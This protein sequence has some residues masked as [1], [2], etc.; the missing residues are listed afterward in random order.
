M[1]WS[2]FEVSLLFLFFELHLH[3]SVEI[4]MFVIFYLF[5]DFRST[6]FDFIAMTADII[7]HFVI[8]KHFVLNWLLK[9]IFSL[10]FFCFVSF[11]WNKMMLVESSS[12]SRTFWRFI[13][14]FQC[15]KSLLQVFTLKW[16]SCIMPWNKMLYK[17]VIKK[18]YTTPKNKWRQQQNKRKN[19]E[20]RS[21]KRNTEKQNW[22]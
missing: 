20:A 15:P 2:P 13:F 21:T 14:I 16:T 22:K 11:F 18:T 19:N 8:A 3:F 4:C 17:F 10:F 7:K 6:P 9:S 5:I 12:S 1:V